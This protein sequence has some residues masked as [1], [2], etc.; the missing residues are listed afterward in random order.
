MNC[1]LHAIPTRKK[2]YLNHSLTLSDIPHSLSHLAL[3]D[4]YDF[5]IAVSLPLP[6]TPPRPLRRI[7]TGAS[8]NGQLNA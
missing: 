3:H 1:A 7:I 6:A 8:R 4:I 5:N 2:K